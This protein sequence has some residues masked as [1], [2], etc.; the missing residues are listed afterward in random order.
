MD[1][2]HEV[3]LGLRR[4]SGTNDGRVICIWKAKKRVRA[5]T[6]RWDYLLA[7]NAKSDLGDR[8]STMKDNTYKVE[9]DH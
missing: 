8:M 4:A 6:I 1:A 2:M 3:L 9:H 5:Q 7:K